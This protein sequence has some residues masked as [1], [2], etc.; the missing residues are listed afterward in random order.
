MTDK[1]DLEQVTRLYE[2][3]RLINA[4]FDNFDAGGQIIQMM[5][6]GGPLATPPPTGPFTPP[7]APVMLPTTGMTYPAAMVDAI[8]AEL[9]KRIGEINDDLMKLGV[10]GV[11]SPQPAQAAAPAARGRA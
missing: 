10:T 5:I 7:R 2:E 3:Y 9:N 8:K 11:T 4:A 6:S 1:A